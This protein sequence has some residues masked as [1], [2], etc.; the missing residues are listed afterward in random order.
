MMYALGSQLSC[1]KRIEQINVEPPE[2]W[3]FPI[4]GFIQTVLLP[5]SS[6]QRIVYYHYLVW[7]PLDF[8]TA[9]ILLGNISIKF[10]HTLASI[11]S[12]SVSTL[13]HLQHPTWWHF[14]LPQPPFDV[15]PEIFNWRKVWIL[16]MPLYS[17]RVNQWFLNH[18]WA[19]LQIC[20]GSL[21]FW[22]LWHQVGKSDI[23]R[24]SLTSWNI[25][26]GQDLV[27]LPSPWNS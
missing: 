2:I 26:E 13:P 14:I 15:F 20:L 17:R 22:G 11:L 12:H 25:W 7:P 3:S 19:F 24:C 27:N 1:E 18:S 8:N 5:M 23:V 9:S 21:L 16:C 6:K 4:L 10:W